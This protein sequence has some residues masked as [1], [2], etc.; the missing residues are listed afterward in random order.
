MFTT[1][2]GRNSGIL[3]SKTV[4]SVPKYLPEGR[5]MFAMKWA[6]RAGRR[7]PADKISEFCSISWYQSLNDHLTWMVDV[8]CILEALP[9]SHQRI[10]TVLRQ[11][12]RMGKMNRKATHTSHVNNPERAIGQK[13]PSGSKEKRIPRKICR[14]ARAGDQECRTWAWLE[15]KKRR[16][17]IEF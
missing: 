4:Y 5:R 10:P 17:A 7:K 1:A 16:A 2:P 15:T 3:S 6:R 14:V 12:I 8:P 11:K 9:D 13:P